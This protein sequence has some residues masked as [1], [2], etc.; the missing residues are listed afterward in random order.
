MGWNPAVVDYR[1]LAGVVG[2]KDERQIAVESVHQTTKM[3]NAALDVFEGIEGIHDAEHGRRLGHELHQ[4]AGAR[5]GDGARVEL[6][7]GF[8]DRRDEVDRHTVPD[9]DGPDEGVDV[10]TARRA[11]ELFLEVGGGV[12]DV[13]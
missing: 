6:R 10:Q 11:L 8:D 9:G 2:G 3:P 12:G 4:P 7:L 1:A 13:R 5:A